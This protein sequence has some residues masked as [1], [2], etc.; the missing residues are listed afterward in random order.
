MIT[1]FKKWWRGNAAVRM[2]TRATA[3]AAI[4]YATPIVM[5]EGSWLGWQ[6][7]A[8][9]IF[10]GV[11]YSAIGHFTPL[12]PFVGKKAKLVEVPEPPAVPDQP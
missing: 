10:G 12:E 9:A 11:V 6:D 5:G 1:K 2:Y 4:A 8:R 3:V 7:A